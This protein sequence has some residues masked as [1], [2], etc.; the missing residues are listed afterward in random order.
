[1]DPTLLCY[2]F[3]IVIFCGFYLLLLRFSHMEPS[4]CHLT[5]ISDLADTSPDYLPQPSPSANGSKS[6]NKKTSSVSDKFQSYSNLKHG[7]KDSR[8][9]DPKSGKRSGSFGA[10]SPPLDD[11][12]INMPEKQANGSSSHKT[13]HVKE[14]FSKDRHY[15]IRSL[16]MEDGDSQDRASGG[17]NNR[18]PQTRSQSKVISTLF[19]CNCLALVSKSDYL[20]QGIFWSKLEVVSCV[21]ILFYRPN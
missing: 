4:H 2:H 12:H 14:A 6:S 16:N 1:M 17:E 3:H 10:P 5:D 7:S 9:V 19:V 13:F 21:F 15:A 11:L 8:G 20:T 18:S